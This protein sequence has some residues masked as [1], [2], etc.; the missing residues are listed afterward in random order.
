MM[1]LV[2]QIVHGA[3]Q[4][5]WLILCNMTEKN[6]VFAHFPKVVYRFGENR[7]IVFKILH[8]A[9]THLDGIP[10]IR[11]LKEE[12]HLSLRWGSLI[13]AENGMC[14]VLCLMPFV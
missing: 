7:K 13:M 1:T 4:H 9:Q 12:P 6:E 2:S 14:T 5:K 11:L 10:L 8:F 3:Q